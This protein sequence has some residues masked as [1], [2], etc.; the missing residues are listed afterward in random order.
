MSRVWSAFLVLLL[1]GSLW[2]TSQV[3]PLYSLSTNEPLLNVEFKTKSIAGQDY[4]IQ[5]NTYGLKG[6]LVAE[7]TVAY[8]GTEIK[9]YSYNRLNINE[10]AS[11][12]VDG[13]AITYTKQSKGKKKVKRETLKKPFLAGPSTLVYIREHLDVLNDGAIKVVYYGVPEYT[14]TVK[15]RLRKDK[16]QSANDQ[17]TILMEPANMLVRQFVDPLKFIVQVSDK[18]IVAIEGRIVA[19]AKTKEKWTHLNALYDFKEKP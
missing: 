5:V 2:A 7:E 8:Q 4:P 19:V 18:S 15:F 14:R 16:K 9:A 10:R 13:N 11:C 6:Q 12:K 1:S 17:V 3:V